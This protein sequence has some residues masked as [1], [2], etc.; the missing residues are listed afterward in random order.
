MLLTALFQVTL[1]YCSS[2]TLYSK[3][4]LLTLNGFIREESMK[5][6]LSVFEL[7]SAFDHYEPL[8]INFLQIGYHQATWSY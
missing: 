7:N 6:S 3:Q 8:K 1:H 5:Y 4:T 2:Q